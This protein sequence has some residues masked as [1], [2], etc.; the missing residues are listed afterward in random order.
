MKALITTHAQMFRTPD[1][2]IWTDYIYGYEF[3]LRYLEIF[4]SIRIVTRMKAISF[5]E[6][7]NKIRVDGENIEFY[8]LPFYKGPW[9]YFIKML[10]IRARFKDSIQGCD[11]AVLR[12]PDQVSFQLFNLAQN[13]R[14]P[15]AVEVVAHPWDLYAPGTIRTVLRPFLRLYWDFIQKRTCKRADGVA[16][17][18]EKY[19]QKRYPADIEHG[20]N[21]RF[22]TNYTSADLDNSYYYRI[23]NED[24]F[25]NEFKKIIHVS[26]INNLSKG[27]YELLH[28]ILMLKKKGIF[29]KAKFVG[30]GTMLEYFQD[31]SIELRLNDQVTFTGYI[32]D[33]NALTKIFI[34]SDI[35]VLPSMSEGLPRVILEAMAAGLP[36]IST[37]VGGI[38]DI[39]SDNA[40]V[41]ANDIQALTN[42]IEEFISDP[43]LLAKESKRNFEIAKNYSH[44]NVQAKRNNFY[45]RLLSLCKNTY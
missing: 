43:V 41:N 38:P 15:C 21:N 36:C 33:R 37:S 23:R 30:G 10:I 26:G 44:D 1:G 35:L 5:D 24:D 9:Q 32:S 20:N 39:L 28:S 42:R 8:P 13:L 4:D 18:T 3:F 22:E 34:D 11:C 25:T 17:V 40:L 19:L 31:L 16:Y 45:K 2:A 6:A 27:H 29:V 12:I 7:I 14:I